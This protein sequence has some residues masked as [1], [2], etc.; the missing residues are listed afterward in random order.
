MRR[1]VILVIRSIKV[2]QVVQEI[3][4]VTRRLLRVFLTLL[5]FL[6]RFSAPPISIVVRGIEGITPAVMGRAWICGMTRGI[7]V[8]VETNVR[9][10]MSATVANAGVPPI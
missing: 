5:Q 3:L 7:A 10:A 6:K 2:K 4:T 1:A 9:Q 8:C